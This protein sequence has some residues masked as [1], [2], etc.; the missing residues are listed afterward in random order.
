LAGDSGVADARADLRRDYCGVEQCY[1]LERLGNGRNLPDAK[2]PR[3]TSPLQI[4][5]WAMV[6][7]LIGGGSQELPSSSLGTIALNK[8][9]QI[10]DSAH[11]RMFAPECSLA[12]TFPVASKRPVRRLSV[13]AGAIGAGA[14]GPAEGYSR[15]VWTW[16]L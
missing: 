15:R 11:V 4:A 10:L 5:A 2:S 8:V 6:G 3:A 13:D 14:L 1:Y 12:V 16:Q 9:V 7:T